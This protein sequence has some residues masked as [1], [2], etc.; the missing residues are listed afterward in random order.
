VEQRDVRGFIQRAF[1]SAVRFDS[2][3]SSRLKK[4]VS[5]ENQLV[6][7]HTWVSSRFAKR[8]NIETYIFLIIYQPNFQLV[9]TA[10]RY[11]Q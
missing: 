10:R 1:N 3:T 5:N 9:D 11:T 4:A 2:F 8:E 6:T 7:R